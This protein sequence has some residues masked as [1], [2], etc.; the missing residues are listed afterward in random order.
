[1]RDVL[2][3]LL[4]DG[5]SPADFQGLKPAVQPG[6]DG[7]RIAGDVEHPEPLQVQVSVHGL[8]EH[9]PGSRQSIEGPGPEG[10]CGKKLEVHA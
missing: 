2:G 9:L 10:D 3:H 6:K 5:K 1:M 4:E 7:R 8:D